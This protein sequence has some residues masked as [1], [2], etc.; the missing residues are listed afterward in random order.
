MSLHNKIE[1]EKDTSS[2]FVAYCQGTMKVHRDATTIFAPNEYGP[3]PPVW[4]WIQT[5]SWN[6]SRR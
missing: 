2:R 4:E 5:G 6:G 3:T 1:F